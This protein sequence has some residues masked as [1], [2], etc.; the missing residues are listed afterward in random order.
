MNNIY[1]FKFYIPKIFESH[2]AVLLFR[3]EAKF[4]S[5]NL[6]IFTEFKVDDISKFQRAKSRQYLCDDPSNCD[7]VLSG[8]GAIASSAQSKWADLLSW[9]LTPP[10]AGAMG[11]ESGVSN[12][13]EKIQW[14]ATV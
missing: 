11:P 12:F 6:F 9:S 13:D 14:V 10:S 8:A 2:E 3:I 4:Q 7:P 1:F 5:F